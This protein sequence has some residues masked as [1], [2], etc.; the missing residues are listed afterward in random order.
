MSSEL[1]NKNAHLYLGISRLEFS[2]RV[3]DG[4]IDCEILKSQIE[5]NSNELQLDSACE[6]LLS[7]QSIDQID[8]F[9]ADHDRALS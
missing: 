8:K 3:R 5:Q 1:F 9:L 2:R 7:S 4:L 6:I